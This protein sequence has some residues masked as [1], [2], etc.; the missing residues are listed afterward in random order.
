MVHKSIIFKYPACSDSEL[1]LKQGILT[2]LLVP[3][4]R[5]TVPYLTHCICSFPNGKISFYIRIDGLKKESIIFLSG[6]IYGLCIFV[7]RYIL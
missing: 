4:E 1:I 5:E 6:I 3:I 2:T 7:Y